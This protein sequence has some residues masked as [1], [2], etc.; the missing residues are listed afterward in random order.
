M[1]LNFTLGMIGAFFGFWMHLWNLI[2]SYQPDAFTALCIYCLA[3]LAAGSVVISYVG[4]MVAVVG[5]MAYGG[6]RLL[7]AASEGGARERQRLRYQQQQQQ[8]SPPA[9]GRSHYE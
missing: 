1:M 8:Q 6:T 4:G 3:I 7:L 2:S 5:G 9:G